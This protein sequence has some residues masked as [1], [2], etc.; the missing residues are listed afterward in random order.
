MEALMST[1]A[2]LT[3]CDMLKAVD[4]KLKLVTFGLIIKMV[5]GL[6]NL[7]GTNHID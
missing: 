1:I 3:I 7:S 4:K 6:V 5:E 2:S